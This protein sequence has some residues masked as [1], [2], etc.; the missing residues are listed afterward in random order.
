[1]L[2]ALHVDHLANGEL[3]QLNLLVVTTQG[4]ES[5]GLLDLKHILEVLDLSLVFGSQKKVKLLLGT[6]ALVLKPKL[7]IL[8]VISH[9][10][11]VLLGPR[12]VD[13]LSLFVEKS[14]KICSICASEIE[15]FLC[16]IATN[17]FIWA[18]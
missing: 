14:Q 7:N 12:T 10:V 4:I 11:I 6:L 2:Q 15:V 17:F 9:S 3:I 13:Q 5:V 18:L 1:M 16:A 8:I